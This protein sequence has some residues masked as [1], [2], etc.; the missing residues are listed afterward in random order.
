MKTKW[1]YEWLDWGLYDVT[2]VEVLMDGIEL[3]RY[4]NEKFAKVHHL[5]GPDQ[6]KVFTVTE[7]HLFDT[8]GEALEY[9]KENCP[10]GAF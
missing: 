3:D 10:S 9:A 7:K 6:N 5:S 1:L 8:R 4:P 2:R